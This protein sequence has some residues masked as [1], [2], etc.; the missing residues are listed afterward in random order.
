[1]PADTCSRVIS[2]STNAD[3]PPPDPSLVIAIRDSQP[4]TMPSPKRYIPTI[5]RYM[6]YLLQTNQANTQE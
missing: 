6:R 1:M 4:D 3:L 2:A 5:T